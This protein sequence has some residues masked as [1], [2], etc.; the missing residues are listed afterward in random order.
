[1][2]APQSGLSEA[3]SAGSATTSRPWRQPYRAGAIL[4]RCAAR[5]VL[6]VLDALRSEQAAFCGSISMGGY[7]G[8]WLGIHAS[9]RFHAIVVAIAL[10]RSRRPAGDMGKRA[11][12]PRAKGADGMQALADS[13]PALVQ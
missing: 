5:D 3:S 4:R 12:M 2:W 10:R 7:T 9:A 1:M 13:A 6:A 11:A 8:L